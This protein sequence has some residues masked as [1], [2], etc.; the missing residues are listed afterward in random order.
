MQLS[1]AKAGV[2]DAFDIFVLS[3][4]HDPVYRAAE[5]DAVDRARA[6]STTSIGLFYR[7]RSSNAGRKSGNIQM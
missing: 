6:E 1:L 5:E 2:R 4:A 3:D 7:N